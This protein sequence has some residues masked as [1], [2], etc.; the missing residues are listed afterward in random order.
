[1]PA[2]GNIPWK[3]GRKGAQTEWNKGIKGHFAAWNKGMKGIRL[4]PSSEFKKGA[5]PWNKG[6]PHSDIAREKNRQAHLGR[7]HTPETCMKISESHRGD[8][9][10][11]W[12]GGITPIN[13]KIRNSKEYAA[14]RT[15]VFE[16]DDYTCQNCNQCGGVL[17]AD[18]IKPFSKYPE[19][20][21]ELSN[22]RTLCKGCH[23]E[24]GWCFFKESNPRSRSIE[25]ELM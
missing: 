15:A 19:L 7:T 24:I 25:S 3:K 1:M 4:S 10:Y 21:L 22:G 9:A 20:R 18:H 11:Q 12:K 2:R 5:T 23:D 16:R 6:I 13:T 8:K 14:W 17:N